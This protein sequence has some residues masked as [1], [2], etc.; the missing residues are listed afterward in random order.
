MD[1]YKIL[2]GF[3]KY[4]KENKIDIYNEFSFQ[5]ELGIYLRKRLIDYKIQFERNV[6]YFNISRTTKHEIDIVIFKPDLSEKIAIELKYPTNGQYPIQMFEFIR[7]I[8]FLE[9]LKENG[10]NKAYAYVYVNDHNFYEGQNTG[11][12]SYFRS[13]APIT[14]TITKPTGNK[15]KHFFIKGTYIIDWNKYEDDTF[16]L[17]E[18][19]PNQE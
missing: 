8:K 19:N 15:D 3:W 16:Y 18:T 12:Y 7:D 13:D 9:E 14:G 10:F 5:F 11:I 2:L 4:K 17:L 6:S 1:L